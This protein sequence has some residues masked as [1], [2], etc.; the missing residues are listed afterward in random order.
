MN[1]FET[2]GIEYLLKPFSKERFLKAWNKFLLLK[3][4]N[5]QEN[6]LVSKLQQFLQNNSVVKQFKKRFTISTHKGIYFLDVENIP[7]FEAK[8][9]IVF[10][11]DTGG[12]KHL[13]NEATLKDLVTQI[14]P[15]DFF[16]INRSE[17]V[18]KTFIERIERH[19]KNTIAIQLKGIKGHL[20]TSQ[21][22]TSSFRE[23]IKN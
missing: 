7:F 2:N 18:N 21:S 8:E 16:R 12:K 22:T 20:I 11:I 13:I 19:T 1:A 23:W 17:V 3:N 9:G 5:K 4:S 14:D 10:A 15:L 6:D